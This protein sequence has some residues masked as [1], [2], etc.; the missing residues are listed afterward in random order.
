MLSGKK[1]GSYTPK[2]IP[3][4]IYAAPEY[5]S[6]PSPKVTDHFALR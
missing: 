6:K 3:P 2:P 5:P 1:L 4:F